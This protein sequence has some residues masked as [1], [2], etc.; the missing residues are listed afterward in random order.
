VAAEEGAPLDAEGLA[1]V[2]AY[3]DAR[4]NPYRRL[5]VRDHRGVAIVA[6]LA[7]AVGPDYLPEAVGDAARAA[8]E[9]Y[10]AFEHRD[11]GA[12]VYL[13]DLFRVVQGVDG[14]LG[15]DFDRLVFRDMDPADPNALDLT[16][17]RLRRDAAGAVLPLQPRL[18]FY[19]D[20]LAVLEAPGDLVLH[21]GIEGL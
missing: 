4:R 20:E 6:T 14:V 1:A 10:F 18:L 15:V 12:A 19:G 8:V 2:R 21:L 11:L 3:L 5:A 13:S 17:R 9:Q 16:G 7:L